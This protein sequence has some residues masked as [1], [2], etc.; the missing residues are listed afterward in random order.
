MRIERGDVYPSISPLILDGK[1]INGRYTKAD[2]NYGFGF[3]G[4]DLFGRTFLDFKLKGNVELKTVS[5]NLVEEVQY[6]K[7]VNKAY[8]LLEDLIQYDD[9]GNRVYV[10]S[11]SCLLYTSDAADE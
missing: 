8:Q 6:K 9:F 3:D 7:G 2:L 1:R 5:G 11:R 10:F 4:I